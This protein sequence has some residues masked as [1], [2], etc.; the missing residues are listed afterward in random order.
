M[1]T[2]SEWPG[3]GRLSPA[4]TA[5]VEGQSRVL[6]SVT[7]CSSGTTSQTLPFTV[8][9]VSIVISWAKKGPLALIQREAQAGVVKQKTPSGVEEGVAI[10]DGDP[11]SSSRTTLCRNW[12]LACRLPRL[13]RAGPSASLDKSVQIC[14][15]DASLMLRAQACQ[16]SGITK[17]LQGRCALR[18]DCG[19]S[20]Y[21]PRFP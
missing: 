2:A 8:A 21:R 17:R 15:C 7:F 19:R 13:H 20:A 14:D 4:C 11:L 18:P 6:A 16:S 1:G 9:D 5:C 3:L 12:H 10:S